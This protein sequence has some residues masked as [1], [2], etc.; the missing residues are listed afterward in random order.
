MI[1]TIYTIGYS[2]FKIED[3][4]RILKNKKISV[5]IDVRSVPYSQFYS[6]Y[7]KENLSKVL[8]VNNIYYR[9]YATEFGARQE[10][11]KYYPEGYLDFNEFSKSEKFLSG[12]DRLKK[13]MQQNYSIVLMCSEK[14]P[15]KCHRTIL[16]ARAFYNA[17]YKVVHLLPEEKTM[18]QKDVEERLLDMYF[19]NREQI[20][21]FAPTPTLEEYIDAVYKIQNENIG[22]SIEGE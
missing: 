8:N 6:E 22:Y 17:G 13:S 3:F 15:I 16:V 21:M 14:D 5:V 10:D 4:V 18:T 9:N 19:P 2:G 7:N 20:D 11:R 1:D 12:F